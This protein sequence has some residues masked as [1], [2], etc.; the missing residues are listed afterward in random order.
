MNYKDL[1]EEA[2]KL[3]LPYVGVSREELETSIEKAK[4]TP[5]TPPVDGNGSDGSPQPTSKKENKEEEFNTAIISNGA[6]EIRRYTR[7]LHGADFTEL[8]EQFC[9]KDKSYT[10]KL[11]TIKQGL[12]CPACGHEFHAK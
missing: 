6:R 9:K 4:K 11:Q 5:G 8:A 10:M 12:I 1:Q 2:K 3:Q 7:K